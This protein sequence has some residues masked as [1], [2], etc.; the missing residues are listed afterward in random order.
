MLHNLGHSLALLSFE[1]TMTHPCMAS[2][3]DEVAFIAKRD[4]CAEIMALKVQVF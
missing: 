3:T 1:F 2:V 4:M